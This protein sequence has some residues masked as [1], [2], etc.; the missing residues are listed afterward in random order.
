MLGY[1]VIGFLCV[2]V[3]AGT[4]IVV[5]LAWKLIRKILSRE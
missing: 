4:A 5:S 2:V 1:F 3:F